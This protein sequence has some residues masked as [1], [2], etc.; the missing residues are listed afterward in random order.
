MSCRGAGDTRVR[1][2]QAARED[3]CGVIREGQ[4]CPSFERGHG[5]RRGRENGSRRRKEKGGGLYCGRRQ[6]R[7]VGRAEVENGASEV[8]AIGFPGRGPQGN[9]CGKGS[10]TG[11]LFGRRSTGSYDRV[12]EAHEFLVELCAFGAPLVLRGVDE[13]ADGVQG[14]Y[15]QSLPVIIGEGDDIAAVIAEEVGLSRG[16]QAGAR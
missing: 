11:L 3:I 1:E 5:A 7:C 9:S 13:S 15:T 10:Y 8:S 4:K 12:A 2:H 16:G 14:G 6:C